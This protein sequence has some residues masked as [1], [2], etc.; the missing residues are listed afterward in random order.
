MCLLPLTKLLRSKR[1]VVM[2]LERFKQRVLRVK[3]LHPHLARAD[4][5]HLRVASGATC[6]LHQQ[7]K[8]PLG[9]AEVA[10][11]QSTVGVQRRHQTH[12]TKVVA[13]SDHLGAYQ[14][15]YRARMDFCELAL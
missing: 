8:Q 5:L 15:V 6:G 13:L 3:G 12:S 2:L 11:K 14:H 1:G 10:R 4:A 9:R 7:T